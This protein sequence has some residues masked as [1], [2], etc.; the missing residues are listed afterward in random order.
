MT[1]GFYILEIIMVLITAIITLAGGI[2]ELRLN[3]TNWLNR[4][5]ALF[6]FSASL[7]FL[8]YMIY[9]LIPCCGL[10][11]L[12]IS[13]MIL[14]QI[15]FNFIPI[16]LVMTVQIL[17][18]SQK[19]ATSVKYL[20]TLMILFI[21]MSFGYFI[22]RPYLNPSYYTQGITDTSTHP[23]LLSFV[24]ILRISLVVYIIYKYAMITRKTEGETKK[25]VQWF[26]IGTIIV[27]IGLGINLIG[28]IFNQIFIESFALILINIGAMVIIKGFFM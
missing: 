3:P 14:A 15:F 24:N 8:T 19:V 25:R 20:G 11:S 27:V 23:V 7:G 10:E 18:K 9:H 2:I 22:W 6:F 28:G 12:I 4:W 1:D 26:F 16:S 17:E 5:F 21:I 13:I